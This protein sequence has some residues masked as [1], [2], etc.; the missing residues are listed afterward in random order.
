MPATHAILIDGAWETDPST[1]T[2][3][4]LN[5]STGEPLPDVYPISSPQTLAR[6]AEAGSRAAQG[7]NHADPAQVAM[8]LETHARLIDQRR[9]AIADIAHQETGLPRSPRLVEVEMDR[10]IDQLRQAAACTQDRSW[11]SARIDTRAGLR[12]MYE[13]LG[14]AAL[15]IGPNNFP[16]AY[17]GMAGGDFAAAIAARNPV[18]AKAHPLHPGT[19]RLLARCAQDAATEAALPAGSVQMFYGCAPADGLA[20]IRMPE[21]TGV[22]F[23]GSRP[24]GLTLK[25]A[26]DETGTPIYLEL[27]SINPVFVL[28][29]AARA[30]GEAIA[31]ML[32]DSMMAACGQQCTCPGLIVL[33]T[34]PESNEIVDRMAAIFDEHEPGVMLSRSGVEHLHRSV[35]ETIGH[36]A[37]V[38]VGAKPIEG[39]P[40][41]YRHTL[42]GT[43][44]ATFLANARGL[45]T[46]MFGTAALVVRCDEPQQFH[47]I[48]RS[49]EG[50]LTGT[51]HH[52]PDDEPQRAS[53][54]RLLRPRV[55]RLI[56]N[57]V[58]TGVRVSPATVHGGPFPA[59]GHP[60]HTA[61]GMPTAIPRF[62]ALRCYDHC[63]DAHLPV[64]LADRNPTGSMMRQIDGVWTS[65]NA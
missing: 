65:S 1:S 38:L 12:S 50:N 34:S 35:R 43:D 30:R 27:S 18:I 62:A 37:A 29:H 39:A 44:A 31:G 45:Q 63:D 46:E 51:I 4:P 8:F 7:L 59:T 21:I 48:A 40:S 16:L 20:L 33:D 52:E 55:G 13:P 23:T 64:E 28:P 49:L 24:A 5:P 41:R 19:S 6:M 11:V 36:G 22:G 57:G 17:N 53:L 10:T 25:E 58:P 3:T 61:V 54:T 60:G 14:G 2:F 15:V 9:D 26:A 47:D 42:L 56:S 32:A